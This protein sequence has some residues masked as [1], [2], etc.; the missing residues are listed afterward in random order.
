MKHGALGIG[1]LALGAKFFD[2][3][4]SVDRNVPDVLGIFGNGPVR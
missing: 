3:L 2:P 1:P 4:M